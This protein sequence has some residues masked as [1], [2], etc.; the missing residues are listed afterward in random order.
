M[1]HSKT[2]AKNIMHCSENHKKLTG[3]CDGSHFPCTCNP[4]I[5]FLQAQSQHCSICHLDY[6]LG[7]HNCKGEPTK[8]FCSKCPVMGAEEVVRKNPIKHPNYCSNCG[9]KLN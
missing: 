9:H 6:P 1:E 5:G 8:N 3:I 2:C 7:T 4:A